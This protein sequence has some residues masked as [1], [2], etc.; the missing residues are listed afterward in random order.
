MLDDY[1]PLLRQ[2]MF[3]VDIDKRITSHTARKTFADWCINEV[4]L[5]EEANC[6]N[7][8]EERKGANPLSKNQTE[9]VT[10]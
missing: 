6:G 8:S 4:G 3:S 10:R 1:N 5:S 2:I 9:A 7:R